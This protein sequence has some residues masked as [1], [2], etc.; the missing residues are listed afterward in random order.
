MFT[1]FVR[2][3][4]CGTALTGN[5]TAG[6]R[7]YRHCNYDAT[8]RCVFHSIRDDQLVDP[9]LDYLY[10]FFTDEPTFNT[11]AKRAIPDKEERADIEKERD[12]IRRCLAKVEK[13]ISRLVDAIA[14]G[15][16]PALLIGKQHELKEEKERNADRL[17]EI[18]ARLGAM[19]EREAL[20]H[21]A[22]LIRLHLL[23]KVQETDWHKLPFDEIKQFLIFMFGENPG[24]SGSAIQL[25]QD[26]GRWRITFQGKVG[27]HHKLVN[28]RPVSHAMQAASERLNKEMLREFKKRVNLTRQT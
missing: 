17:A 13:E 5:T 27:F 21:E 26:R 7:Y 10:S 28:G 8:A 3:G 24:K 6:R 11:A 1:G 9:V 22:K 18:E 19:P 15:A 20:E 25:T 16:D 4:H 2:C 23:R 14:K 12:R